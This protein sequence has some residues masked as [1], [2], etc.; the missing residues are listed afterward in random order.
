MDSSIVGKSSRVSGAI[1]QNEWDPVRVP[2]LVKA[3]FPLHSL[4]IWAS[5]D[6]RPIP[7]GQIWQLLYLSRAVP[8]LLRLNFE[9]A[10]TLRYVCTIPSRNP[11]NCPLIALSSPTQK[12]SFFVTCRFDVHHLTA[13]ISILIYYIFFTVIPGEMST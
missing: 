1:S 9:Q 6:T 13:A 11:S 5:T 12:H 10:Q 7:G 8:L 2:A 4:L 3:H